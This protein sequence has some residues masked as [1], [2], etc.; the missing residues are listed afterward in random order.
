[1]SS[2]S[3][4]RVREEP[5]PPPE[6]EYEEVERPGILSLDLRSLALF[7]VAF[8]SVILCDLIS[9][10]PQIGDFYTDSSILPRDALVS[11]FSIPWMI[12][13]HL[14]T[15]TWG[16]EF[17]LFLVT[18]AAVLG[19]IAGYHTRL[20]AVVTWLMIGSMHARNGMILH[21]GDDLVRVLLF[22]CMFAPLNGRWSLD[23][24]LNPRSPPLE[25]ANYSWGTQAL[26]LQLCFVYWFTAAWKWG[27]VWTTEG[28]AIYYALSLDEFVTP[29][30]KFLLRFPDLLP[31]LT[32]AA[33]ALELLGP[34]VLFLPFWTGPARLL[35]VLSFILFHAGIG[36]S[37]ALGTFS[38]V[39]AAAWLMFLPAVFW[40][41]L[42][43]WT[44]VG[45]RRFSA[46][47]QR[48]VDRLRELFA[49][50]R[51]PP[52][53]QGELG[54]IAGG[55]VLVC[56]LVVFAGSIGA[57]PGMQFAIPRPL[58]RI[59]SAAQLGQRWAMFAPYPSKE[60]G[61]FVTEGTLE[62][63]KL[64]DVWNGGAPTYA[65][66]AD[67]AATYRDA[68]WQK[69]LTN[70]WPTMNSPHRPY[71]ALYL[72]REWNERHHDQEELQSITINY[73]LETTPPPGEPQP[74]PKKIELWRQKCSDPAPG[75]AQ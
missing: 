9:C 73:M 64:V 29:V 14:M 18:I 24:A 46:S 74:T 3:A 44:A 37:L 38:W 57:L 69:Y 34:F 7:R 2:T 12:S 67:V 65:K 15:G 71:F 36:L 59:A 20:S 47:S 49:S 5:L 33:Y 8:G 1:M 22:W 51:P 70:L 13:L 55:V 31:V 56:A 27:P 4:P 6:P 23:R 41:R 26:M 48:A 25:D 10:I 61:W 58:A 17:I 50:R 40:E 32:R 68:K 45:R 66:P 60:D 39:C 62:S 28:S 72:C 35:V 11:K 42:G 63:G 43:E 19:M 30:G 75:S 53:P 54:P 16:G 52:A 21:G